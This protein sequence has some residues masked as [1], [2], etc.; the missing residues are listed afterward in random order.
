[1]SAS[2]RAIQESISSR[3]Y[4]SG[5]GIFAPSARKRAARK[6]SN[7]RLLLDFSVISS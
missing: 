6:S 3:L 7:S 1:M 5:G 2:S 4:F